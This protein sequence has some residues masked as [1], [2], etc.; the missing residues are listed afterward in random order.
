MHPATAFAS[1]RGKSRMRSPPDFATGKRANVFF[2]F[3]LRF[4]GEGYAC[5]EIT[6]ATSGKSRGRRLVTQTTTRQNQ[7]PY[8]HE[9]HIQ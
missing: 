4:F 7:T 3:R 2:I 6:D 5:G 9:K 8:T 1:K